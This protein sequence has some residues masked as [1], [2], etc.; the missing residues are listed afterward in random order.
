MLR[1][2]GRK[3]NMVPRDTRRRRRFFQGTD[4][5]TYRQTDRQT[6]R[7]YGV[8]GCKPRWCVLSRS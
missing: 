5:Q 4:R 6:D 2:E 1:K 3:E 8:L 7:K